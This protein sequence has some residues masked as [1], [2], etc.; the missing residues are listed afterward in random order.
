MNLI[1]DNWNSNN[2]FP[3]RMKRSGIKTTDEKLNGQLT[4]Q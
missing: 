2:F 1:V 3:L 4:N